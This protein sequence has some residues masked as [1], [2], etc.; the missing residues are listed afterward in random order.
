[1]AMA[2]EIHGITNLPSLG[3]ARAMYCEDRGDR[4]AKTGLP[5]GIRLMD[6][7]ESQIHTAM[8]A[9]HERG[10]VGCGLL[11]IGAEPIR[12]ARRTTPFALSALCSPPTREGTSEHK[13]PLY[14]TRKG[15]FC[16]QG[17]SRPAQVCSNSSSFL[18]EPLRGQA[19]CRTFRSTTTKAP[20]S[21]R[22]RDSPAGTK[23]PISPFS[24]ASLDAPHGRLARNSL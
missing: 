15:R 3:E 1:M 21:H 9:R 18:A 19:Y 6:S 23:V 22:R 10:S 12:P 20:Q 8:G 4:R 17:F 16:Q 7:M 13:H 14:Y 24:T 5:F 2:L 11:P